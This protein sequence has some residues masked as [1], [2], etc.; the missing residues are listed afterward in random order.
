MNSVVT[1]PTEDLYWLGQGP[2]GIN[3]P[4]NP[5]NRR[6]EGCCGYSCPL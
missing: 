6:Q 3:N 5:T 1:D 4:T 2:T